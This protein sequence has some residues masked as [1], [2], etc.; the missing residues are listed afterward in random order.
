MLDRRPNVT[1]LSPQV[2]YERSNL[3]KAEKEFCRDAKALEEQRVCSAKQRRVAQQLVRERKALTEALVQQRQ[4]A[5]LLE[6]L[7]T[8]TQAKSSD[9][10]KSLG[11]ERDKTGGMEASLKARIAE[12]ET[13]RDQLQTRLA[14]EE[15]RHKELATELQGL[16]ATSSGKRATPPEPPIR[17]TP[18]AIPQPKTPAGPALA[19]VSVGT[20]PSQQRRNLPAHPPLAGHHP[21]PGGG[22]GG[23]ATRVPSAAG[24]ASGKEKAVNSVKAVAVNGK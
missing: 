13:E 18:T 14:R 4:R 12:F 1:P 20:S 15:A 21:L 6:K 2:E 24:A 7:L 10:E 3:R 11:S 9:L 5:G 19:R 22:G 17:R 16:R 8:D 23:G